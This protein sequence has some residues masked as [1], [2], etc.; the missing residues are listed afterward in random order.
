MDENGNSKSMI[1]SG[2]TARVIQHEMDHLDGIVYT[3]IMDPKSLKCTLWK[4]VNDYN[5]HIEI[6]YY[7]TVAK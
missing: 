2:W 1:A 6:Q 5:G 4:Q 7:P 3:D